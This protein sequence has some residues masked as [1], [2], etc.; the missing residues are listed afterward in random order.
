MCTEAIIQV[1]FLCQ[2]ENTTLQFIFFLFGYRVSLCNSNYQLVIQTRLVAKI[3]L[4][5]PIEIKAICYHDQ[6]SLYFQFEK[7]KKYTN[8]VIKFT[9]RVNVLNP[10]ES[11]ATYVYVSTF[12]LISS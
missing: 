1:S 4:P 3:C 11:Q 12:V 9:D 6:L 7:F 5:L 2:N 8:K 10:S